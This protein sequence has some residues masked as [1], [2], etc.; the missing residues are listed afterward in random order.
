MKFQRYSSKNTLP[1]GII[2][3]YAYANIINCLACRIAFPIQR[4][5]P[6]GDEQ[7]AYWNQELLEH[8]NGVHTEDVPRRGAW[9][10]QWCQGRNGEV[11]HRIQLTSR[12]KPMSISV[13]TI[14]PTLLCDTCAATPKDWHGPTIVL[15]DTV[16]SAIEECMPR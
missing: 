3:V 11:N 13:M 7:Y 15:P 5:G 4:T 10:M 12:P 6:E 2:A 9:G 1:E 16:V 14:H 8:L